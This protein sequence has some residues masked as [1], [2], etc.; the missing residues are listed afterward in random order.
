V[1]PERSTGTTSHT[2]HAATG[3]MEVANSPE[4]NNKNTLLLN[5][6]LEINH[7]FHFYEQMTL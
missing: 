4:E 2:N 5:H 3:V 1:E 7:Q 6:Y